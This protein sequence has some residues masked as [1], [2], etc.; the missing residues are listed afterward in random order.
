[1]CELNALAPGKISELLY[2]GDSE[3][4]LKNR[5]CAVTHS[6]EVE[7]M[8][9]YKIIPVPFGIYAICEHLKRTGGVLVPEQWSC[10]HYG[11]VPDVGHPYAFDTV[12]HDA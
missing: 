1:M 8:E 7:I 5:Y 12:P 11:C 3:K 2:L 4:L 10:E 6:Y 9:L